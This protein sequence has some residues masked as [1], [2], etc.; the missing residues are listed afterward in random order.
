MSETQ[1]ELRSRNE[2][3]IVLWLEIRRLREDNRIAREKI[4]YLNGR[5]SALREENE[6]HELAYKS[7][8]EHHEAQTKDYE[9]PRKVVTASQKVLV[10]FST[11]FAVGDVIGSRNVVALKILREALR[12]LDEAEK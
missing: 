2:K 1:K 8:L 7:L 3:D 10:S 4:D 5:V 11:A 6:R 9:L 12:E